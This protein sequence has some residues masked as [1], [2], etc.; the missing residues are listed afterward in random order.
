[1]AKLFGNLHAIAFAAG[2]ALLVKRR[3]NKRLRSIARGRHGTL[4]NHL[5]PL[6]ISR[7][8][9]TAGIRV[10]RWL[11]ITAKSTETNATPTRVTR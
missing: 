1:V 5:F 6:Q 2:G 3:G 7:M 10:S 11:L 4:L 8:R 9:C